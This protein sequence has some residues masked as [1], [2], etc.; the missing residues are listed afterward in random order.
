MAG[1]LAKVVGLDDGQPLLLAVTPKE[2]RR[3]LTIGRITLGLCHPLFGLDLLA[4]LYF[5]VEWKI[6]ADDIT[7]PAFWIASV[8]LGAPSFLPTLVTEV[9][10]K[11]PFSRRPLA[12]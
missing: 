1:D 3:D 11:L 5:A 6:S 4:P 8:L 12:P 7:A 2:H 9:R 10:R